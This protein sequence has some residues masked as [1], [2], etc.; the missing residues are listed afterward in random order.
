MMAAALLLSALLH[1]FHVSVAEAQWNSE[2]S[3]L[4]VALRL[5]PRDLDAALSET[6]G[7]RVVLEKESDEKAKEL[8]VAYLR[9]RIFLS[10]SA[11]DASLGEPED[12]AARRGRFHWVGL[13]QELRYVWVY[14]ELQRPATSE[15]VWLTNRVIFEAEPTQINTLQLL[16]TDPPVAVRTTRSSDTERLPAAANP[17]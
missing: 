14:F 7:L 11:A 3:R 15:A 5:H 16:R 10:A 9:D 4:K 2:G 13:E 12:L 8:L 6:T 1:P 17:R